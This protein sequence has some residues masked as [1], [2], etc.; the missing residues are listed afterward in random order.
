MENFLQTEK[1]MMSVL[2]LS[3]ILEEYVNDISIVDEDWLIKTTKYLMTNEILN[4]INELKLNYFY[5]NKFGY[6]IFELLK[7]IINICIKLIKKENIN[8]KRINN[9][10]KIL[11]YIFNIKSEFYNKFGIDWRI[12]K[13]FKL[14]KNEMNDENIFV[15]SNL[16]IND[17]IDV[18]ID[19]HSWHTAKIIKFHKNIKNKTYNI[20]VNVCLIYTLSNY[21]T[22]FYP[23]FYQ[24]FF[25]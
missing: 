24:I 15:G 16:K 9:V 6:K 14:N 5:Y 22:I 23:L 25:D 13:S 12:K 18:F 2:S 10:S 11:F 8:N 7:K 19:N 4:K 21:Y 20:T 3:L 1:K 17:K